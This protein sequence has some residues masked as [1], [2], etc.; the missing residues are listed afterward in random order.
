M[1]Q[2]DELLTA[3]RQSTGLDEFGGA[4]FMEGLERLV[5]ALQ[6]EAHLTPAGEL[7]IRA[8][9]VG[10]LSQRLHVE[11]WY[12]RHPEIEDEI[13]EAPLVGVS[14]PRTGSTALAFLLAE[15]P[16]HR[17]L[18]AWEA[19]E[20]CPPPSTVTGRDPR[21]ERAEW[22][23]Q[24]QR[25][26]SPRLAALVPSSAEGP[27]DC[28]LLMGLDFKAPLFYAF[29]CIPSYAKWLLYDADL[30]S[31]YLYLRRVLKL[32]Q[33]GSSTRPWSLESPAH[34]QFIDDLDA[35]FPDAKFVM[36]HR[37]P[38][39]V[40]VSGADV[41]LEVV[42][43]FNDDID[44]KYLGDLTKEYWAV[45]MDR[46][47][48]FRER[49][50]DDRFFDMDFRAMQRDPV[51]EVRAL[52]DWLGVPVSAEF[53]AGMRNWWAKN[54]ENREPNVHPD[55]ERFGLDLDEVRQLFSKYT[56]RMP[57]WIARRAHDR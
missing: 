26:Y 22:A 53:E 20:P 28:Q 36:T 51:G 17:S 54:S 19:S 16:G 7:A 44:T 38:T 29:A 13:I 21:I 14:L 23:E 41:N 11:D 57:G 30:R 6:D 48:E 5:R 10:L 37:D 3:A 49:H 2:V 39:E 50:G 33:W 32:L 56:R 43:M 9:L 8:Q 25:E 27:R 52:Y 1:D 4:M 40:I 55:P 12:R 35:V 24:M 47:I 34:L 15:D 31:A 46:T 18:R 42:K 45:G